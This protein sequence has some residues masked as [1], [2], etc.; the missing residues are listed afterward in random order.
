[1]DDLNRLAVLRTK[2][3]AQGLVPLDKEIDALLQDLPVHVAAQF[4]GRHD[5]V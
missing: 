4:E 2:R 3:R 1:M 5:V